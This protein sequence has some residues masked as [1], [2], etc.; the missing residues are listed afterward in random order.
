MKR[1]LF[2]GILFLICLPSSAFAA[3]PAFEVS[4]WIPYWRVA[5]GT[6]DAMSH[7]QVFSSV[8]PFG[9]IIQNDGSIS[10]AFGMSDTSATSTARLLMTVAKARGVK[11]V[12]AVMW[13][14]GT[15]M[16]RILRST[17]S[18]IALE[19]RIVQL[20]MD[21]GFDGI[22][23]DFE[24]KLVQTRPYFSLFLK[25][26]YQRMGKK[27]VYCAIE[28]RTPPSSAY[29]V[30]PNKL[31]YV[32]DYAVINSYCDRVE[33][34]TYDQGATDL[35][36]NAAADSVPYV[37]VA[38]VRWVEKVV[39]LAAQT[40][41]KNKIIIGI[42]TYGYEYDL[43]PLLH[44]FRYE[45]EWA[46]NPRYA[47]ELA[48]ELNLT[49]KR[50]SAGEM[51]FVYMPTTTPQL[52]AAVAEPP[53]IVWWSD[54]RAVS[55]KIALAKKLGVRGVALFKIDGGEDPNIWNILPTK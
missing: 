2:F 23:I 40:I 48:S 21:N 25:E 5:T 31:N 50:N 3:T 34:M 52:A 39:K 18:R 1:T 10:D 42:P 26:L 36:L 16:Y 7:M 15:A 9:Y 54:A 46:F 30:I 45:M 33:I 28:P 8:M 47:I 51:S 24:S 22:D 32:N 19:D 37:P 41:S 35:R 44:G 13:S 4:G 43:V 11:V 29:T 49:P 55:D 17:E 38:D 12:P 53:H 20:V 14:N 6:T 27:L